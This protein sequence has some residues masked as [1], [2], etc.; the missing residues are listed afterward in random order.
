VKDKRHFTENF[1]TSIA[2]E[3]VDGMDQQN[4][5]TDALEDDSGDEGAEYDDEMSRMGYEFSVTSTHSDPAHIWAGAQDSTG[6][7]P[8]E[9][10]PEDDE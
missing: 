8:M 5:Q 6:V 2:F 9:E 1:T 10:E 3:D 7:D 4:G